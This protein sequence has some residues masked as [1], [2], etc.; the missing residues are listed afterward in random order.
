MQPAGDTKLI[1]EVMK[2]V[3]YPSLGAGESSGLGLAAESPVGSAWPISFRLPVTAGSDAA[4]PAWSF[5]IWD[6]SVTV[7]DS[8]KDLLPETLL[9]GGSPPGL[10]VPG[11]CSM[12][13]E[14][15]AGVGLRTQ[16]LPPSR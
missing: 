12:A 11:P 1:A 4:P 14:H 6:R 13:L 10:T 15:F 9:I 8:V 5:W 7:G 3:P 16:T 2:T